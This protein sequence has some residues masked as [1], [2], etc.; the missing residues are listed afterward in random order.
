[1]RVVGLVGVLLDQAVKISD[2]A[3]FRL[4]AVTGL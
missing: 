4:L 2:V 1:M 3:V